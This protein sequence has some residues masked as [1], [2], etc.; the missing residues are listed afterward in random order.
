[1]WKTMCATRTC[2]SRAAFRGNP[3]VVFSPPPL[4]LQPLPLRPGQQRVVLRL[5]IGDLLPH[6]GVVDVL[7][8]GLG[9]GG[10]VRREMP[11]RNGGDT[12]TDKQTWAHVHV[13]SG[14]S[15]R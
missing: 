9:H 12:P 13:A 7:R 15:V 6:A 5:A 1:M 8:R 14:E 10:R 2:N 11:G 3:A 4:L